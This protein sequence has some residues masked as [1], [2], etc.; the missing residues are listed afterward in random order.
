MQVSHLEA[1]LV[2][3]LRREKLAE[4]DI[5]KLE[6]EIKHLSR[7]VILYSSIWQSSRIHY[8]LQSHRA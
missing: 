1:V 6:A 8:I 7:L 5:M 2:G 3:S 4:V